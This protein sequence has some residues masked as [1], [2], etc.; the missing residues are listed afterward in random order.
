M[1]ERISA[2]AE[3][4]KVCALHSKPALSM[5]DRFASYREAVLFVDPPYPNIAINSR[6][7]YAVDMTPAEHLEFAERL[8]G[9]DA[10]VIMTMAPGTIYDQVLAD[11]H[12]LP[13]KVR[14]L[15]NTVKEERIFL[16]YDPREAGLF[17]AHHA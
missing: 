11:W 14:G 4:L 15:R 5:V 12:Q 16:N 17:A 13:L 6:D 10:A 3:R 1:P 7:C 8:R 9:V 2:V